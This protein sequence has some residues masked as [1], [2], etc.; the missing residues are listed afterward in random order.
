MDQAAIDRFK[1]HHNA[2]REQHRRRHENLV[3]IGILVVL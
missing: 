2:K 1:S 3:G